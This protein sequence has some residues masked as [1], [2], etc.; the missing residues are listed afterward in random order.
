[1][2]N[3]AAGMLGSVSHACQ[4]SVLSNQ[5][6]HVSTCIQ[7]SYSYMSGLKAR[8]IT[9]SQERIQTNYTTESYMSLY[10]EAI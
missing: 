9:L 7:L 1:M 2:W 3:L 8:R 5:R 10:P 6:F 4:L